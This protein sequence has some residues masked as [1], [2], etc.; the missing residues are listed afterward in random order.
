[1]GWQADMAGRLSELLGG[2]GT[3]HAIVPRLQ[4]LAKPVC[5]ERWEALVHDPSRLLAAVKKLAALFASDAL[6]LGEEDAAGEVV[7]R[8]GDEAGAS[9]CVV[10][11]TGAVAQAL[12]GGWDGGYFP[13][14]LKADLTA[15]AEGFC[16]ARV[17]LLLFDETGVD[18]ALLGTMPARKVYN[19]LRNV[20]S[21]FNVRTGAIIDGTDAG[22][23]DVAARL[24]LDATL[25]ACRSADA[26]PDPF[27]LDRLCEDGRIAGLALPADDAGL[28]ALA[29]AH[30][31]RPCL[32]TT[33]ASDGAPTIET[34][35]DFMGAL[36]RAA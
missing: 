3:A 8:L 14:A 33:L 30:V 15:L 2:Q 22:A 35:H 18:P 29:A 1:M 27:D 12:A 4:G 5:G 13:E 10:I 19:T 21:Y 6:L 36:R 24:R 25:L 16:D 23:I 17:A 28:A 34:M 20:A 11:V 26:L 32:F 9:P 7:R 31:G